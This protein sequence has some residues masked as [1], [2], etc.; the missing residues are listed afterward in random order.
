MLLMGSNVFGE[1]IV[2]QMNL[3]WQS[4]P[5]IPKVS[6]IL[7]RA[8]V[9]FNEESSIWVSSGNIRD[10]LRMRDGKNIVNGILMR[11]SEK[12]NKKFKILKVA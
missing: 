3:F 9:E 7:S 4:S 5:S 8:V 6:K 10:L 12:L 1:A 11:S 2:S